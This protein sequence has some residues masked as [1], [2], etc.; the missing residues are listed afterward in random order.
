ME[1]SRA[2]TAATGVVLAGT[3]LLSA[4]AHATLGG[5]DASFGA[6]GRVVSGFGGG[7]RADV[8]LQADGKIVVAGAAGSDFALARF[9]P[10]GSFDRTFSDDGH[11]TTDFGGAIDAANAVAVQSDGKI[12]AAGGSGGAFAIA[13]YNA[14]G[15]PDAG[16]GVNG[17]Q[18]TELGGGGSAWEL[19]IQADGRIVAAGSCG[20]SF[21]LARYTPDGSPDRGFSGD[22]VVTT[23][24]GGS[25][26]AR[27]LAIQT[28]G[29]LV[30]AGRSGPDFALARYSSDG[31][32]DRTFSADGLQTTDF[33]GQD[34][35]MAVALQADGKIVAGGTATVTDAG[36]YTQG[37]DFAL[38]RYASDGS[39]DPSFGAGG[40]RTTEL[41][42]S[43]AARALAIEPDGG[44]VIAGEQ[45]SLGYPENG[46][47]FAL[48]HYGPNGA[49]DSGAQLTVFLGEVEFGAYARADS[50]AIQ[51]DGKI[52]AAGLVSASSVPGGFA[53]ARYQAGSEQGTAPANASPPAIS[54][55]ATEGQTLTATA[56]TWIGNSSITLAHQWRRCD[57]AAGGCVDIASATGT[58][59][60]PASADVGHT[61][62]VRETATNPYGTGTADSAATAMVKARAGATAGTVRAAGTNHGIAGAAVSCGG[63]ATKTAGDGT[64]SIPS[65]A[66]GTYSCT[67]SAN[68]YAPSTRAITVV[69]GQT[70]VAD[71]SL[72]R[73]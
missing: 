42:W 56:G 39:L 43:E 68:R 10:D 14:D 2:L 28:D 69:S 1:L 67:A 47:V 70:T 23:D 21:A 61:I 51:P 72:T 49:P 57:S 9:N 32:L 64:Y 30:A 17:R 52:V 33:G 46:S 54:G 48:A 45:S 34:H 60:T 16:F 63:Y 12:I 4:Q 40:R 59:Y 27:G 58:S 11:Q 62:R 71:F 26:G 25:D 22:G 5:L 3:L 44:I 24:V 19:A 73:R 7:Y 15:S 13:R 36:G 66:P 18:T 29:K 41:N 65:V 50:L 35:A 8:A 55:S 31:A 20:S 37:G 38:A 6:S 53:L